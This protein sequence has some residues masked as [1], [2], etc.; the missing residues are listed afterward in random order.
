M[1]IIRELLIQM[2][3][4]E[5]SPSMLYAYSA[6]L[7][8]LGAIRIGS[9]LVYQREKRI[10]RESDAWYGIMAA[11]VNFNPSFDSRSGLAP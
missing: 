1:F 3:K 4:H 10:S 8:V 6:I 2:Y 11:A 9:V 5:A 7:F